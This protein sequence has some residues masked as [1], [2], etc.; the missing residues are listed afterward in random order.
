MTDRLTRAT[1]RA[2]ERGAYVIE[3]AAGRLVNAAGWMRDRAWDLDPP[4]P[5]RLRGGT[6]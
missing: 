2:L 3:A 6:P 4:T 5:V 1:G